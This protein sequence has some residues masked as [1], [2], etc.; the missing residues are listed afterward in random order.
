LWPVPGDGFK[1]LQGG[2]LSSL[3]SPLA[4]LL[5][6]LA[7]LLSLSL[8]LL[9]PHSYLSQ[10]CLLSL[11]S[12]LSLPSLFSLLSY[13]LSLRVMPL[14]QE[15]EDYNVEDDVVSIFH[16]ALLQER[17]RVQDAEIKSEQEYLDAVQARV[18]EVQRF[19][20]A[21]LAERVADVRRTQQEQQHRLLRLMNKL[22]G[23]EE[24]YHQQQAAGVGG[25]Y[26]RARDIPLAS[27]S[28][29]L[30]LTKVHRAPSRIT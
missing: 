12:L 23:S 30:F 26:G 1:T 29:T 6:L 21:Q 17:A 24:R 5:Y 20:G 19:R 10:L 13:I 7:A 15:T 25:G 16:S 8:S 22:E 3:L 18:R 11:L 4:S 9:S 28:N 27:S 14:T 2:V